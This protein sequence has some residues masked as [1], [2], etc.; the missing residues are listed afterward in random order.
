MKAS[1]RAKMKASASANM[2]AIGL[3]DISI[4]P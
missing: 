4:I 2:K 1:A 3:G